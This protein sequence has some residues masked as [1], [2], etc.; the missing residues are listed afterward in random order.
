M[1]DS[2]PGR[3][4]G[5]SEEE[6]N[7]WDR[8]NDDYYVPRHF[9]Y[10]LI[11]GGLGGV[12]ITFALV[13]KSTSL[14]EVG[15]SIL[16]GLLIWAFILGFGVLIVAPFNAA[17]LIMLLRYYSRKKGCSIDYRRLTPDDST[18]WTLKT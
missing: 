2:W 16:S 6:G 8:L 4:L 17:M 10:G 9:R 7:C 11:I 13:A 12:V 15:M 5:F 18:S 1:T 3:R 14:G